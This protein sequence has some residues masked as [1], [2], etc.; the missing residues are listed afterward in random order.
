LLRGEHKALRSSGGPE[1]T[2][3]GPDK[4]LTCGYTRQSSQLSNLIT[5]A[6]T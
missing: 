3:E 2:S 1:G 6:I 5:I 4:P